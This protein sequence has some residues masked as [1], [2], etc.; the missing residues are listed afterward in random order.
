MDKKSKGMVDN[1]ANVI[2]E[3]KRWNST[4]QSGREIYCCSRKK[5]VDDIPAVGSSSKGE[6]V[7]EEDDGKIDN[8]L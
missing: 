1:F 7:L 4:V 2:V 3:M 6:V 5:L 8:A